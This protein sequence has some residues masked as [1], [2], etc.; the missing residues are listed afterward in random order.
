MTKKPKK[1]VRYYQALLNKEIEYM[2][3]TLKYVSGPTGDA[4]YDSEGKMFQSGESLEI[5]YVQLASVKRQ[6]HYIKMISR[7]VRE[8]NKD[9]LVNKDLHKRELEVYKGVLSMFEVMTGWEV[10]EYLKKVVEQG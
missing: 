6:T 3:Q 10:K 8:L 5:P 4:Q 1:K 2:N 7:T 9:N